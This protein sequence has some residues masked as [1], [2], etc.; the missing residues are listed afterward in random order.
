MSQPVGEF[1]EIPTPL[2]PG[3]AENGELRRR[4]TLALA[5]ATAAQADARAWQDRALRAEGELF[6]LE[7]RPRK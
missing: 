4:L 6:T 1:P 3:L 2:L 7:E 5:A